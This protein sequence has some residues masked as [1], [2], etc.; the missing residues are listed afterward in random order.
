MLWFLLACGEPEDTSVPVDTEPEEEYVPTGCDEV[1]VG[2]SGEDPPHVG[3]TWTVWP[4]CDGDAVLGAA[5]IRV[6]PTDMAYQVDNELTWEKAG[7]AEVMAQSGMKKAYL[8]VEV[9][10]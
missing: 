10:E 5:V 9:L 7:T 4:T 8:T 2:F 3:D 6:D 1:G